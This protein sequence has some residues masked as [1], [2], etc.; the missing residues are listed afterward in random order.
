MTLFTRL[1]IKFFATLLTLIF[2]VLS[3]IYFYADQTFNRYVLERV[4]PVAVLAAEAWL[5]FDDSEKD[6][7]LSLVANLSG[8][9]WQST[10]DQ[11]NSNVKVERL[12]MLSAGAE[13]TVKFGPD[14]TFQVAIEDWPKWEEFYGWLFLNALS[15]VPSGQREVLFQLLKSKAPWPVARVDRNTEAIS[16]LSF[17]QLDK[18][19]A[20]RLK[21]NGAATETLYFPAGAR[22]VIRMGPIAG[23]ELFSV[24]QWFSLIIIS[25]VLL[26]SGFALWVLPLQRRFNELNNAVNAIGGTPKSVQLPVQYADDLGQLAQRI[27]HMARGLITQIEDNK[28]LNQ[29]V[30]HDLK[31]PLA[32][33]KFSLALLERGDNNP[34]VEQIC[35]DVDLLTELTQELLLYH[36]LSNTPVQIT[37]CEI[38][39]SLRVFI[40]ELPTD[41]ELR[42]ALPEHTIQASFHASHW[43]RLCTGLLQNAAQY[44]RGEIWVTLALAGDEVKLVIEDNGPGIA[45]AAFDTLKQPFRRQSDH[46]D[47]HQNNH[48]LGLAL[49][50]AIVE[51]YRGAWTMSQSELGGAKFEVQLPYKR[52]TM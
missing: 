43:R 50:D 32:R 39:E 47:L 26:A 42:L 13:V 14:A 51:H 7:W 19:N 21:T 52:Q 36:Q 31:T 40:K 41:L 11:I 1:Y 33:I 9:D 28:Q 18:G 16:A 27:D 17:R 20:I 23:Y 22:Q 46:R 25:I 45:D 24:T 48:G 49:V 4:S 38:V 30:S 8:T 10:T 29:A 35:S 3:S 44:G 37:S 12:R 5:D 6:N 15:N 34:Y 2:I